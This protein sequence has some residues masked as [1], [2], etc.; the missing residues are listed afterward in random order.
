M[1]QF[2]KLLHALSRTWD[3]KVLKISVFC[4]FILKEN[5]VLSIFSHVFPNLKYV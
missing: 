2:A 1:L 4:L 3:I 5:L